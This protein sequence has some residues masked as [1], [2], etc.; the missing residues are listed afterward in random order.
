MIR[1]KK[2]SPSLVKGQ[3]WLFCF[4]ESVSSFGIAAVRAVL[5]VLFPE[6]IMGRNIGEQLPWAFM[7][8]IFQF[9]MKR[10][11]LCIVNESW[12]LFNKEENKMYQINGPP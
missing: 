10:H 11:I 4:I 3:G 9:E 7:M 2:V 6:L 1:K 8:R 5:L 12:K